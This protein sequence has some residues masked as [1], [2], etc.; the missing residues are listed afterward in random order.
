VP[1]AEYGRTKPVGN[2]PVIQ[3]ATEPDGAAFIE[4]FMTT[5]NS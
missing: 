1:G 5:L 4:Y 3:V 2:G